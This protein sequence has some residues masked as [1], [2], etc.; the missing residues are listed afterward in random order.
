MVTPIYAATRARNPPS[1][2]FGWAA[3]TVVLVG[4]AFLILG[5]VII[6]YAFFGFII[7]TIG[8]ATGSGGALAI[9][10]TMMGAMILFVIGGRPRR[11]RRVAHPPL[12]DLPPRRR[13]VGRRQREHRATAGSRP[14]DGHPRPM[15]ELR[16][17]EP[18]VGPLLHGV[19]EARVT[20]APRRGSESI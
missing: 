14:G 15:H 7:G 16:P 19:P 17:P 11:D 3:I 8:A 6:L 20:V 2:P 12:V 1:L 4:A 13:R 5:I 10:Q 18:R 9:F